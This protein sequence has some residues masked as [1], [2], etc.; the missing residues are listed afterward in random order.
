MVET[1][2]KTGTVVSMFHEETIQSDAGTIEIVPA[3][4]WLLT[5]P[6]AAAPK[7]T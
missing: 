2:A 1:G 7:L 3:W 5:D 6:L 4:R